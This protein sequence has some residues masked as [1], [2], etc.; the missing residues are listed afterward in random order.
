MTILIDHSNNLTVS[1]MIH[2]QETKVAVKALA[3]TISEVSN[4]NINL[5]E[6]QKE[7]L[8]WHYHLRH[9]NFWKVQFII[10]SGVLAHM[11]KQRQLHTTVS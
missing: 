9:L 3:L 6:P 2:L 10:R 5:S 1:Q 11:K 7:L 4:S 8:C